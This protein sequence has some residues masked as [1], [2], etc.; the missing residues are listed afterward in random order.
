MQPKERMGIKQEGPDRSR[1]TRAFGAGRFGDAS[2]ASVSLIGPRFGQP[3]LGHLHH[4]LGSKPLL[5]VD[6]DGV[7]SLFG[8]PVHDPPEGAWHSIDGIPHFLSAAAAR[9]LLALAPLYELVWCSGWEEKADE[10]LPHLLGLPRGIPHLRFKRD[11][12]VGESLHG[13]WKL[14]AIDAYAEDRPLAWV[15]DCIDTACREWAQARAAP[16]L[17]VQTQPNIG[18]TTQDAKALAHWAGRGT[19][20]ACCYSPG[21]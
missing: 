8:F 17:L 5:M 9:H 2:E 20:A 14:A 16:A 10:H 7:L 18:I 13:H 1:V 11:T 3:A 6:V 12:R 4:P 21:P 19:H 15:D